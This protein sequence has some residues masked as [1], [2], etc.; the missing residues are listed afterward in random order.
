V[1]LACGSAGAG[2]QALKLGGDWT[3][4]GYDAAR[5]NA[6]PARTGITAANVGRLVRRRVILPGTV[7]S[8]PIYLR[9]VR[10]RGKLRDVFFLT[11]SYG[12][13][14]ALD[15]GSGRTLWVFTPPGYSS[16]AGTYRI[17]NA[18]PVADP[19][20]RF[21]YSAS[22]D[23]RIH[24]LAVAAGQEASGWPVTVTLLPE[25]EKIGPA[26]NFARGLVLEGTGGYIGDPP[27]YQG[28]V[29]AIDAP[30]GK[31]VNVWNS[32]CSDRR[33]LI[34]PS[35]CPASDSAVWARSGVV[36]EPGSG[37]LLVATGNG[38][39]DGKTNWG[40]SVLELSP[41][42][43]TLLRSWT[44]TNYTELES[45]DVDLGS[46]APAVLGSD[47]VV[48]GGKDAKLRLLRLSALG[49]GMTGGE[50]QTLRTP[51]GLFTSPAVWHAGGRTWVFLATFSGTQALQLSGGNLH[52]VW[53]SS[54]AGTSPVLAGG[55]LY[56]YDPDGGL[57][58][59]RP[60]TGV[61]VTRLDAGS[62]HWNSPIVTDGRIALP[63]GN[64]NSH[65]T[66]GV[67][68]IWRLRS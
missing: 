45:G 11:T 54:R 60:T 47:L 30:T 17:T 59:Y 8:S 39:W 3:R 4:F 49:L 12:K 46:T 57:F 61:L 22:P 36:V 35:S 64:A 48:Q 62:G 40:D 15:A 24:K 63:E 25:R 14:L 27:P 18:S 42:A 37:R 26:L 55:L 7:D 10:V 41:N 20:R 52:L 13:T 38:P 1:L 29:V 5:S 56:V 34:V 28:H 53:S 6:G 58:V 67:L 44:P 19:S 31:L 9:G 66:A 51:G 32:L 33:F 43:G 2:P 16:W 23:G 68:D 21:V 65:V 50:S